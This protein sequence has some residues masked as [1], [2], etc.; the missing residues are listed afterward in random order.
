MTQTVTLQNQ[1]DIP[2]CVYSTF[3]KAAPSTTPS[4]CINDYYP[5]YTRLTEIAAQSTATFETIETISRLVIT[6]STNQFPIKLYIPDFMDPTP[7][8]KI[9]LQDKL[10]CQQAW[11][12]YQFYLSQPYSPLAVQFN[13]ILLT[14]KN[15]ILL[16]ELINDLLKKNGYAG[17]FSDISLL[18]YWV[19][20]YLYS[21]P[22][23]YTCYQPKNKIGGP[24]I[25][26]EQSSGKISISAENKALY[27][28]TDTSQLTTLSY[29]QGSLFFSKDQQDADNKLIA[30]LRT[31]RWEGQ[32]D[33]TVLCFC[34]KIQ[35]IYTIAQPYA[36]MALPWWIIAY[37]I[38]YTAFW[39]IQ[40]VMGLD[41]ALHFLET[42][43]GGVE[44][45]IRN[46]TIFYQSVTQNLAG[47]STTA[48]SLATLEEAASSIE[49]INTD[50]DTDTD[51]DTDVDDVHVEDTDSV[52]DDDTVTDVDTVVDVDVD[53]IAVVDV[54]TDIIIDVDSVSDVD[55]V[56]VTNVDTDTDTNV[57]ID[58]DTSIPVAVEKNIIPVL[59]TK[60]GYWIV[61]KAFPK[62]VEN[63]VLYFSLQ[64]IDKVLAY[65]RKK[66][67]DWLN[68]Q[69]PQSVS[70]V[71]LFINYMLNPKNSEQTRWDNFADFV[72][73]SALTLQFSAD[74][75]GKNEMRVQLTQQMTLLG[76]I[77]MVGNSL[78]DEQQKA[79]RW[80]QSEENHVIAEM[81][82]YPLLPQSQYKAYREVLAVAQYKGQVLPIKVACAVAI[83]YLQ[84][85]LLTA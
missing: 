80:P 60:V 7:S 33:Q 14:E 2:I 41:M 63:L 49:V 56:A 73:Q 77:L 78:A 69:A 35:G 5:V 82:A 8:T 13:E 64:S 79:W 57:D 71:G 12:F 52:I 72:Q 85:A 37:D 44:Y 46:L 9:V 75:Q 54:D 27:Q 15:M 23:V 38:A 42:I 53:V 47:Q 6:Q 55:D 48:D 24:F 66:G 74:L 29:T 62:L 10:S 43:K 50:T 34:G 17:Q 68:E 83:R 36:S 31:L 76:H 32:S 65:W 40:V 11:K 45:L 16:P 39:G 67:D 3:S 4:L 19:Q 21:F 22:G 18:H 30:I 61:E 51:I 59:L 1:L 25:L 84:K 58:I 81:A 20:N 28:A 26:P 70:G